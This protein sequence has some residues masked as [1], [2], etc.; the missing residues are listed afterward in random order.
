VSDSA[1]ERGVSFRAR[2]FERGKEHWCADEKAGVDRIVGGK[3]LSDRDD[4]CA[5][6]SYFRRFCRKLGSG[7]ASVHRQ[8]RFLFGRRR[9]QQSSEHPRFEEVIAHE[10]GEPLVR[11]PVSRRHHG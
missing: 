11:Q 6:Q 5:V 9:V 7:R 3:L 4:A 8:E 2:G 1:T 10:Q